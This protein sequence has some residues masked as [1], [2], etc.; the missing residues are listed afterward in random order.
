MICI[1]GSRYDLRH[2]YFTVGALLLMP[3][4]NLFVIVFAII[5]CIVKPLHFRVCRAQPN[6]NEFLQATIQP[7]RSAKRTGQINKG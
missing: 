5:F 7:Y 6:L 3:Q 4:F 1:Q 2:P